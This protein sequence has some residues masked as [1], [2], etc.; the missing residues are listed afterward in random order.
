MTVASAAGE[1]LS[2][3]EEIENGAEIDKEIADNDKP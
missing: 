3:E 2:H 1:D